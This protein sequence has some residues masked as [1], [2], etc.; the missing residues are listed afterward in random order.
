MNTT[1]QYKKALLIFTASFFA[2]LIVLPLLLF[3]LVKSPYFPSIVERIINSRIEKHVAIGSISFAEGSGIIVENVTVREID[4]EKPFILL[5]R[6]EVNTS[7][8]MLL[9]KNINRITIK[10]P[11]LL[12]SPQKDKASEADWSI[13][14]LRF[15][16][17]N[18]FIE[19][20]EVAIQSKEGKA[21]IVS[22]INL[23]LK[24]TDN[25]K[26][27][28]T[29]SFFLNEYNLSVPFKAVMDMEE[30]NIKSASLSSPLIGSISIKG[31]M[32]NL[33]SG[34]PDLN[35]SANA[36]GVP[37]NLIKTLSAG[38]LPEWAD[39]ADVKGDVTAD[40][41]VKGRLKSPLING[42][43]HLRAEE[44]K[45]GDIKIASFEADIPLEYKME[46]LAIKE[47]SIK[48]EG[49]TGKV[50][51]FKC[52]TKKGILLNTSFTA[53]L[54]K[55]S[56]PHIKGDS[57]L[58]IMDGGFSSPD[59]ATAAEGID[60]HVSGEFDLTLPLK[61]AKINMR[62]EASGFELLTG[63]FYGSFKDKSVRASFKGMYNSDDDSIIVSGAE[64]GIP[65]I[66]TL[67]ISGKVSNITGKPY[68]DAEIKL[69]ELSNQNTFELFLR[70][71]F[72]ESYPM[73]ASLNVSGKTS[74]KLSAK[75][76]REKFILLG[77]LETIDTDITAT[78]S[79][80]SVKGL[81]ISL[82]IDMYYPEAAPSNI[83]ETAH[84]G[85]LRIK[86]ISW[87]GLNIKD[88]NA[89]PAIQRNALLF[90]Q[91]ISI[92]VF[93]GE[94]ALRN[95][96]YDQIFSPER[97]LFL[98]IDITGVDLEKAS[99]ALAIFRL[100]GNL[101][102]SI[103]EARFAGSSLSTDGEI[104]LKLFEGEMRLHN[105]SIN[106]FTGK[107]PSIKTSVDIKEIN[108]GGLT[109]A[110]EF[111]NITGIMSGYIRELVITDGQ[112]EQFDASI[113]SIRGKGAPQWISVEALENISVLGSG[114]STSILNRGIYSLF[115][116]YRYEKIGFKGSLRNDNLLLSG[117]KGEGGKQYLVKGGII[118]PKVNVISYTQNISFQDMVKRLKRIKQIEK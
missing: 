58:R 102:G 83:K 42:M 75:G 98:S 49:I 5:P 91:D 33:K 44:L 68:F 48:A 45:K 103:P 110:F 104:I 9:K 71:T 39:V 8:P 15:S 32:T 87:G 88:L 80:L 47:A 27:E 60:M 86:D 2:L 6:I 31:G 40:L 108:L 99:T 106:N 57:D 111:G 115:K 16:V 55:G 21:F 107:I 36:E 43:L 74:F 28:I 37:L 100:S 114:S 12:L 10:K 30:F 70:D 117:I 41:S 101:S 13:P 90:R 73:L 118:P 52:F 11:K 7:L 116:K 46:T 61:K 14:K 62:A 50:N 76:S 53:D 72:Q 113:E 34:N 35:F 56:A 26:R 79:G 69:A 82:P 67:M 65:E 89:Y 3:L 24:E 17:N 94:V 38:Y 97:S 66:G 92:P 78:S 84:F 77:N 4:K 25:K 95:I 18:V 20:G 59:E 1:K 19:N 22:S 64:L 96:R 63:G 85:S 54:S 109:G 23:S 81:N 105:F 112:A 51:G 29:G 93:D